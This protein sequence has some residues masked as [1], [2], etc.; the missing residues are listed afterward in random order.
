MAKDTSC[1]D[2]AAK[3]LY[4]KDSTFW[5]W[6]YA[7]TPQRGEIDALML[8]VKIREGLRGRI[9]CF[10]SNSWIVDKNG[11]EEGQGDPAGEPAD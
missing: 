4:P 8:K 11:Q 1:M 3:E 6:F 10:R 5:D 9:W 7:K 2:F